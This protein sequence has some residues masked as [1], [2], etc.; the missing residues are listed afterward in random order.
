VTLFV[1]GLVFTATV[2]P[3]GK[4]VAVLDKVADETRIEL[5]DAYTGAEVHQIAGS[6][7]TW[8]WTR[9]NRYLIIADFNDLIAWRVRDGAITRLPFRAH[10]SDGLALTA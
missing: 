6:V 4:F 8:T 2:S 10:A 9:D 5:F 3:D 7:V 1:E